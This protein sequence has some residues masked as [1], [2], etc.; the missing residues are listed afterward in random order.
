MSAQIRPARATDAAA[1]TELL[2]QLGY[3][4]VN[5]VGSWGED[6]SSAAYVAEVRGEVLGV[7]A[8]HV[9]PFFERAGSWGRIVALVVS[10]HARGEGIGDQLVL[11]A[12][13]FV[14]S[15]GGLRMEVTSSDHRQA[16]HAFYRGRGY[17]DQAGTSSRFLRDLA[18]DGG[19]EGSGRAG[20]VR[21]VLGGAHD[22]G[23]L[24]Q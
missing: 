10:E 19:G 17:I 13:S 23:A 11:A 6:P 22:Q 4:A 18:E 9:C 7:V 1:I 3:G 5:R 12:E 2:R 24:D 21:A 8:V 15:R 20:G 16:A 14:M